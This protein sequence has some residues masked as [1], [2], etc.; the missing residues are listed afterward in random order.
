MLLDISHARLA[1]HHLGMDAWDYIHALPVERIREIHVTGIQHFD[2]RWVA[3]LR[4]A[5]LDAG[6]IQGLVGR[7]VDHLP[8]TADDWAFAAQSLDHIRRGVW[9]QPWIVA[10]EYGGVGPVWE[11]VTDMEV[12]REQIPRLY[13]LVKT[14][15]VPES[16]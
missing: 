14:C 4:R 16:A 13:E 7:L 3:L 2:A 1:A 8:L 6:V 11:A 5:G 15:R 12:L 9:G 10:L